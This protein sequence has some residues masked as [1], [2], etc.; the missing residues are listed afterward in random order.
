MTKEELTKII[1]QLVVLGE[2]KD[3]LNYWL[4]IYDDLEPHDQEAV[5]NN[6]KQ[7]LAELQAN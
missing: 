6:L 7:E 1:E 4:D 5:S 2:D 3:E